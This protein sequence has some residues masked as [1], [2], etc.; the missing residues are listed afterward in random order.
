MRFQMCH[1]SRD[2]EFVGMKRFHNDH[3]GCTKSTKNGNEVPQEF[4]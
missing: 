3:E 2:P 1:S 4:E